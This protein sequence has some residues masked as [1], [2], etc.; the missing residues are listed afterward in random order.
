M[1]GIYNSKQ[2]NAQITEGAVC[3]AQAHHQP[4][5]GA[6]HAAEAPGGVGHHQEAGGAPL[7]MT[8]LCEESGFF[9]CRT[10][11]LVSL[12]QKKSFQ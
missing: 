12:Q 10:G 7:L 3:P 11:I 9:T 1:A 2:N 6:A 4:G 8:F 5:V